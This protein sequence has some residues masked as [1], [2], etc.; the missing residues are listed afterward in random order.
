MLAKYS[1]NNDE[2]IFL[3]KTNNYTFQKVVTIL[4]L[5]NAK[6]IKRAFA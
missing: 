1:L 5:G 2:N 4:K 6:Y 3:K